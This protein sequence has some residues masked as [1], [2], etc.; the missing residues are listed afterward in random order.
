MNYVQWVRLAV[1]AL[2]IH[3]LFEM[4]GLL[5]F[6]SQLLSDATYN[7]LSVELEELLIVC[8]AQ[9]DLDFLRCAGTQAKRARESENAEDVVRS[10]EGKKM[11]KRIDYHQ[12]SRFDDM[13]E[14]ELVREVVSMVN[15]SQCNSEEFSL[16][17]NRVSQVFD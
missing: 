2:V 16:L 12:A 5:I 14:E 8:G 10:V 4:R 17:M 11:R 9:V 6:D 3:I 7:V 15:A 1:N 13:G